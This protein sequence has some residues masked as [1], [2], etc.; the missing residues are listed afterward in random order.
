MIYI[1]SSC[2]KKNNIARIICQLA[3]KG[4]KNIELSGGTQYYNKLDLDLI[5]LK[6][7]YQLQY[8][9]HAYFPPSKKPF[10]V[11]LASCN[12]QIYKQS[13]EHY[14][15]C[16]ELLKII[17]CNNLS[18]HAGFFI[19]INKDEIGRK[20]E[21]T[22]IYNKSEACSRFCY[23]YE[24]LLKRCQEQQI[25]LFLENNVLIS[26][27]YRSFE[28]K[29]YFMMTDY[30]SIMQMKEYIN[31]ELLL[32]LGHLY[33]S[34]NTLGLDFTQE[35]NRLKRYVKWLH[36]SDNNGVYDE[37]KPLEKNS[38][39]LTEF[40]KIYISDLNVTL[41]TVGD[42]EDILKSIQLIQGR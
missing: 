33:V 9:C 42:M 6:Q 27:N 15:N 12:D 8:A 1:S 20:I 7:K 30:K 2:I 39:I 25:R 36:V 41:E 23:A 40:Y 3:E 35:C 4:I 34:A 18:I 28:Q 10:V 24:R 32:D 11:N 17:E 21:K 31:F 14:D 22:V 26:E 38:A 5:K 19:E 13:I 29:N 16:I 37:H